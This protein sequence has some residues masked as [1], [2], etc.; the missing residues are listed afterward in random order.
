MIFQE[1]MSSLS[2]VH[3]VGDQIAEVLQL[4]FKL[5]RKERRQRVIEL[6]QQVEIPNPEQAIDDTPLSFRVACVSGL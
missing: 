6:L 1:P 2:P 5:S 4:H 3:R